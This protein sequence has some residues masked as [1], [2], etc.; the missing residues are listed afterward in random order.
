MILCIL[1]ISRLAKTYNFICTVDILMVTE[2]NS[3]QDSERY[4]VSVNQKEWF[5]MDIIFCERGWNITE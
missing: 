3:F 5:V 1:S 2:S 4:S